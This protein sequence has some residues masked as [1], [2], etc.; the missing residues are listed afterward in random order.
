M[1]NGV[2]CEPLQTAVPTA[3]QQEEVGVSLSYSIGE[4]LNVKIRSEM[5]D[6]SGTL[7]SKERKIKKI[8]Y[9]HSAPFCLGRR[10]F[11][12]CQ[13]LTKL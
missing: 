1:S 5:R 13:I 11:S 9:N 7:L 2:S 10:T 6:C 3:V 12:S 4:N 8:I